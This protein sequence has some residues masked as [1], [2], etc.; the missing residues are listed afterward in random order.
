M[1]SKHGEKSISNPQSY[2]CNIICKCVS[3]IRKF[4][5]CKVQLNIVSQ[6]S[7]PTQEPT[8]WHAPEMQRNK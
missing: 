8:G 6:M 1:S 2:F 4:E 5:A 7:L 3:G